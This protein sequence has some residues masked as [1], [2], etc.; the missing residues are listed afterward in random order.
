MHFREFHLNDDQ[1]QIA[2]DLTGEP[3][4]AVANFLLHPEVLVS[5]S[6]EGLTLSRGERRASLS[7]NGGNAEV[8]DA[9]WHPEFGL[10][11]PTKR[12]NVLFTQNS[13]ATTIIWKK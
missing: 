3:Q 8:V 7:F 5:R 6:E 13:L 1:L 11:I 10:S 2:D 9:T 12:I 4:S